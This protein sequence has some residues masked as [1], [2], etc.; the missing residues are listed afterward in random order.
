MAAKNARMRYR[1]DVPAPAKPVVALAE[2]KRQE[3]AKQETAAKEAEPAPVPLQAPPAQ[4]IASQ[5]VAAQSPGSQAAPPGATSSQDRAGGGA[6][7]VN[8]APA[9]PPSPRPPAAAF[10]RLAAPPAKIAKKKAGPAFEVNVLR[11]AAALGPTDLIE[12]GQSVEFR[13]RA[14][15]S[16]SVQAFRSGTGQSLTPSVEVA[17]GQ[18]VTL[19]LTLPISRREAILLRLIAGDGSTNT[20][21]VLLTPGRSPEV[22]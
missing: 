3:P 6:N 5:I 16:G 7:Y 10:G 18:S 21:E 17:A 13:V 11:D 8:P 2:E 1:N 19:P 4:E 20:V 12:A 22:R 15:V 14:S 9:A